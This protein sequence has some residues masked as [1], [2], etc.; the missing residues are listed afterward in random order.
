VLLIRLP[1][2]VGIGV[3]RLHEAA[4][5][6]LKYKLAT[7]RAGRKLLV[8]G[9]AV[10][11]AQLQLVEGFIPRLEKVF[12]ADIP[13]C[14]YRW[15][16]AIFVVVAKLGA[17][18]GPQ[19]GRQQVALLVVQDG[20]AKKRLQ[21]RNGVDKRG[22]KAPRGVGILEVVG[23]VEAVGAEADGRAVGVGW[24]A[25]AQ[26]GAR[27]AKLGVL[28]AQQCV[29]AHKRAAVVVVELVGRVPLQS[30]ANEAAPKVAVVAGGVLLKARFL[31]DALLV[32][33][34]KREAV[35]P[36][37]A[38]AAHGRAVVLER[39]S[40]QNG[41]QRVVVLAQ[42]VGRRRA[43]VSQRLPKLVGIEHLD[44]AHDIGK[45]A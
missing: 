5:V 29:Q 12:L 21:L 28:V 24:A 27:V 26:A 16:I 34:A 7:G 22:D 30:L 43:I 11:H 1:L 19:G 20:A 39:A 33:V 18:V 15:K 2:Q 36:V 25:A 17:A 3:G 40:L 8:A 38:A 23:V 6:G 45:A 44:A 32:E 14:R 31:H 41:P 13:G 37:F 4:V 9:A 10:A 35:A 42:V